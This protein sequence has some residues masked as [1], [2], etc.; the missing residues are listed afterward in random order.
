MS[1]RQQIALTAEE[2]A[3][4]LNEHQTIV[5]CTID[6][7]GY[8]H[9]VAMWFLVDGDGSVLMTTYDK[10][11]KAMNIRRNP[12]VALLVES[13]V[14]YDQLRGVLIRGRAELIKDVDRCATLLTRIHQKMGGAVQPGIEEVMKAQARKRV[15]IRIVPERTSS[16]DHGKLGGVY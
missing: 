11:Q 3:R 7:R 12:K 9:A 4:F 13:G 1:R 15:L 10:S 5:L 2:Q 6:K 8:P 16:W 14:V